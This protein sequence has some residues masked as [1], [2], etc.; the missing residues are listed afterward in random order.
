MFKGTHE[1]PSTTRRY[2]YKLPG[3]QDHNFIG[4]PAGLL[5]GSVVS[6][7][8]RLN[9]QSTELSCRL[10]QTCRISPKA[11]IKCSKSE[12]ATEPG[13]AQKRVTGGLCILALLLAGVISVRCAGRAS[14]AG[15]NANAATAIRWTRWWCGMRRWQDMKRHIVYAVD[16]GT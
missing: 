4:Y 6:Q 11:I 15:A 12:H 3:I 16:R 8:P 7:I 14:G 9:G 10:F 1:T 2:G 5:Q 13:Y